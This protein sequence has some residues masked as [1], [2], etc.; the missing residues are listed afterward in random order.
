MLERR[1]RIDLEIGKTGAE[2]VKWEFTNPIQKKWIPK[3]RLW[4]GDR[5]RHLRNTQ[6]YLVS[7]DT[8]TL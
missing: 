4:R 7:N 1:W 3:L 8:G 6:T 5:K 2:E